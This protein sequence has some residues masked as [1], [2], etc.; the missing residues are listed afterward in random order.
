[1]KLPIQ[2]IYNLTFNNRAFLIILSAITTRYSDGISEDISNTGHT[3]ELVHCLINVKSSTSFLT[4][5]KPG[6]P[7]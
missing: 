4:L 3:L 2:L 7:S 5:S 6:N 1:M